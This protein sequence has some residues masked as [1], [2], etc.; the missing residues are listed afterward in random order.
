MTSLPGSGYWEQVAED[1]GVR[2]HVRGSRES[3]VKVTEMEIVYRGQSRGPTAFR[4]GR[5]TEFCC[6]GPADAW[7]SIQVGH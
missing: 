1:R 5:S 6:L 2:L 7:T 4:V 3:V